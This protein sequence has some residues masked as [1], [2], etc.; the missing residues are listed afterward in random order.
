MSVTV[1]VRCRPFSTREL[2]GRAECV[3]NMQGAIRNAIHS[4][5]LALADNKCLVG[6]RTELQ[7]P[8]DAATGRQ[9]G[10]AR[11]F[12]Y[13]LSFWSHRTGD[14]HY[15]SQEHVFD[16]LGVKMLDNAF[17][18]YAGACGF[19]AISFQWL[20]LQ[21]VLAGVRPDWERQELQ[22]DGQRGLGRTTRY[23]HVAD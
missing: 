14:D 2:E 16:C 6:N 4:A 19:V 17:E 9:K 18:G 22:H 23:V 11:T 12:E 3:V 1:A 21:H 20:Q 8:S 15:A 5:P 7:P 10:V 13:D